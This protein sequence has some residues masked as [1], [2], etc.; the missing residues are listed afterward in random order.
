VGQ[1]GV[2]FNG[3][4]G[5]SIEPASQV[6]AGMHPNPGRYISIRLGLYMIV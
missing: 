5:L 4:G 6:A 1:Q 3:K 2:F